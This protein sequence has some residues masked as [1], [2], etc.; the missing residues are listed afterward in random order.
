MKRLIF[1]LF[2]IAVVV[3]VFF[4]VLVRVLE[5]RGVFFPSRVMNLNPSYFQMKWE[6]VWLTTEDRV[7]LN[8]WLI[9]H[10]DARG[11]ILF[12]H[13]NAGNISDR[14]LKIRFFHQLGYAVFI[15]D[16]RG[17]GRSEGAP[18]EQGV[19]RDAQAAFDW[20][21]S[22]PRLSTK[23]V[24]AYGVSLGGAVAIDLASHRPVN[25]LIIDSSITSA[26]DM[27]NLLYPALPKIF[28]SIK[29]D[30]VS[31]IRSLTM[32]KAFL[33]SHED[34]VVPF[35]MGQALFAQAPEPKIFIS[36]KGGHNDVQIVNDPQCTEQLVTFLK[37]QHLW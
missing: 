37:A 14:L 1:L 22:H 23:K 9:D 34:Q 13:G 4:F 6:D 7:K 27:A 19:Y 24:I 30:N 18:S 28:M 11:V 33:H 35:V 17:F 3:I 32:P 29:F 25:G 31:K 12:N 10:P 16:Y 20:I 8:G 2:L 26:K 15:Y 5:A 21:K 36:F